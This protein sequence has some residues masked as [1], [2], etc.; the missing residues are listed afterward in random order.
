MSQYR[1]TSHAAA[2]DGIV[3]KDGAR[4]LGSGF[5][6]RYGKRSRCG[7]ASHHHASTSPYSKIFLPT[8]IRSNLLGILLKLVYYFN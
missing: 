4:A 2:R 8:K 3:A 7:S 6:K 5:G 1:Q